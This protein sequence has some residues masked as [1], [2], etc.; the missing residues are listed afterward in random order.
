[1]KA[2]FVATVQSHIAQ[3]HLGAMKLLKDNGYE[4]HVAA[5]NNLSEKNGLSLENV[6]CVFDIPFDRSPFSKKNI[7]AYKK[8]K[9]L[10]NQEE[11]DIIHCNTP[12]GGLLTRIAARKSKSCVIYTAHGFHFYKGAPLKNW[13]I[14]YPI[15]KFLSRW[16]DKLITITNE[17]YDLAS[18]KFKCPVYHVHGVG[19]KTKKYDSVD[20]KY[21]ND[22]K[23]KNNLENKFVMLCTGELNANKNQS[24]LIESMKDVVKNIP[25]AVLLLAG[26][27]LMQKDLSEKISKLDLDKNVVLLGY[28]T[29]LEWYVHA[30][31][32]ILTAS[33]REGLPVNVLEAMY[34][35]KPVIA[36]NN[37][38]HRELIT[39]GEN[40]YLVDAKDNKEFSKKVIE[41]FN[42]NDLRKSMGIN[43]YKKV[44]NY[45]DINV[46]N[47]LK[48][49]YNILKGENI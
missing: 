40:G 33:F 39:N 4:V 22:F 13:I 26:N 32:L 20:E 49:I 31:D 34:C 10:I 28:R 18:K 3:F 16:T 30:A 23:R 35:Q 8:L 17:D 5:K 43:G 12:V 42:D 37:R 48:K 47:E 1:M 38:G 36:S 9:K 24:T 29:D 44:S 21:L 27:G 41:L 19:V 6:D 25:N 2:L 14:Y 15:E 7:G 45:T 11:Y 46:K